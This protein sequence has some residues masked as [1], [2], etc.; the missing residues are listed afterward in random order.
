MLIVFCDQEVKKWAIFFVSHQGGRPG[1]LNLL[2]GL[3]WLK[4]LMGSVSAEAEEI[5]ATMGEFE[6]E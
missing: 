3:K 6:I 5:R 1:F 2:G 4:V